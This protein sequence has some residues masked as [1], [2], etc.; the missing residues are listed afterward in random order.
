M[1]NTPDIRTERL[2]ITPFNKRHLTQCYVGWLNDHDLMRYSRHRHKIHTIDTC[3]AY[4]QSFGGTPNF[5]WAIE[6]T[7]TG[8]KHIGNI[9]AY[10]DE[11]NMLA[12]VSILI[13]EKEA[14]N[15]HFGSEA[16]LAVC[17]FLFENKGMRKLTAG[18]MAVN[19][20]MIK[21]MHRVGMVDDGI[22][23]DHY[24]HGGKEVNLICMAFFRKQ[25]QKRKYDTR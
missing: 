5:Y 6:E 24:L 4:W 17:D 19:L 2:L 15:K 16:W 14:Q 21:L 22:R 18:T 23:K 10:V 7:E 8:N 20:P 11:Y 12:D 13:G 9:I 1:A 25:W 3:Y